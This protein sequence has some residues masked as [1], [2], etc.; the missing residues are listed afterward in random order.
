M[1]K[2]GGNNMLE[3]LK[4]QVWKANLELPRYGLIT[5]TWG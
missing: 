1:Y 2:N 3:S 5:F 4:V